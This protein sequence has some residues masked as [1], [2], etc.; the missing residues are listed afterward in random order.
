MVKQ[1]STRE[2]RKFAKVCNLC[3]GKKDPLPKECVERI[4]DERTS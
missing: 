3:A 2:N 1:G 4:H